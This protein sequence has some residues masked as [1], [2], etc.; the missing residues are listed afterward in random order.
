MLQNLNQ[1]LGIWGNISCV[2][3]GACCYDLHDCTDSALCR[4]QEI[5]NG[6]SYC[7][8]HDKNKPKTCKDWFCSGL[9]NPDLMPY[10]E[11]MRNTARTILKTHD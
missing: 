3:C 9:N 6:K 1:K 5:K 8:L 11:I 7:V 2:Q 10:Q 4:N